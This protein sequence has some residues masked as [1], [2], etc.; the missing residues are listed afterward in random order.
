MDLSTFRLRRILWCLTC[1]CALIG[2]S[3]T[4]SAQG[5]DESLFPFYH[6]VA[7][8]DPL[9]DRVII[10]TRVSPDEE[11]MVEV[12]WRVATD[13]GLTDVV[14]SGLYVTDAFR[15]YTVKVDVDGLNPGTT[16]YY[17]FSALGKA[18]MVGKTKTAPAGMVDQLKF[19]VVSCSNYQH[20]YFNGFARIADR[21]DLDAVVHLG[22]YIY[23][24][25]AT[26]DDFYGAA[27]LRDNGERLHTPDKE[28][29][30][31][32]DY[33]TRYAQYRQDPD[34]MRVHQQHPFVLVWD[35]HESANDAYQ[36]GA[37]N[38]QPDEGEWTDRKAIAKQVYDEWMPVR[39]DLNQFPLYR[40]VRYGD[41]VDLI[42]LDTRLEGR[43]RQL[44]NVTD[45]ALYSADRTI[46]GPVQKD[47]FFNELTS[48]N[49]RWKVIGNQVIFS[50]FNVWWAANPADPV[51][52]SAIAL[53]SI[54]LDIWD[55]YPSER[56]QI[57][58]YIAGAETGNPIDNVV[59]LTGD[60]HS[61]FGY[62]VALR[63][64]P[65]SGS[66]PS[67]AQAQTAPVPVQPTY[68]PATG[69][70]SVAVE[71][72]TPSITSANF[73]EN[74]PP[75]VAFGFEAQI[76]NPLPADAGPVA[77]I[78]PNPHMKY[79]DLDRHGYFILDITPDRAQA[80]WFY[81]D[82]LFTRNDQE[83]FDEGWYTGNGDNFLQPADGPSAPKVTQD[84]AAPVAPRPAAPMLVV[85][86]S[87]QGGFLLSWTDGIAE[88][89]YVIERSI[90]GGAFEEIGRTE[91]DAES[92]VDESAN[93]DAVRY[94][95]K[96]VNEAFESDYSNVAAAGS[97]GAV[98]FVLVDADADADIQVIQPG[99]VVDL[100]TLSTDAL[101]VRAEFNDV[102]PASVQFLLDGA[103]TRTEGAAPY[104][105]GGDVLGDYQPVDGLAGPGA[106]YLEARALDEGGDLLE[107]G[108]VFFQVIDSDVYVA[109]FVLVDAAAD[110]DLE[111]LPRGDAAIDPAAYETA[112]LSLR[113]E[114]NGEEVEQVL[115][116]IDGETVRTE[117]VAPYALGGDVNGDYAAVE[118]L[119]QPGA[120]EVRATPYT[121]AG[122][123]AP[124]LARI[125]VSG[126]ASLRSGS[127]E[128]STV[129]SARLEVP[130]TVVLAGNYPNPFNPTTSIRFGLPSSMQTRIVLYDM[131]GRVIDVIVDD[132][133]AAGWHDA[134]F[135]GS[136]LASG[137]Y[138]YQLE[139]DDRVLIGRMILQK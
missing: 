87:A 88:D 119:V 96:A 116:E 117:S 15:D 92:F 23:E 47:W 111:V 17:G 43:E 21:T 52:N 127:F 110:T 57:I 85:E 19:A 124:L 12:S 121:S 11:G 103:V 7:S 64:A 46:L 135:D 95:I 128:R 18:S 71:F 122:P 6:G 51:L 63:P 108:R 97:A 9:T 22:D 20:G 29:L 75:P 61:A 13:P 83:A 37:E 5:I 82:D 41:L 39:S 49:A 94:R 93:S 1:T 14:R 131:L 59:I 76:N 100:R 24:I 101:S 138:I 106:F 77:G 67:I 10:W 73:D 139:T 115:F 55:G 90:D 45:P 66:D 118:E 62:D 70:G 44:A 65:L 25:S 2:F 99:A 33:R 35:D 120:F 133:L 126:G 3:S 74:L 134:Q 113:A 125:Q 84:A 56:D 69:E 42:M 91:E 36:D 28:I 129:E 107:A 8:G 109:G 86:Q 68:N 32:D 38:H 50:E 60:F 89:A 31:L 112:S 123:G 34:L 132:E 30:S 16:Y 80:D 102:A 27:S 137:M 105:L 54:F 72:A 79:T 26:G 58:N 78:N 98:T 130:E 40:T 4:A 114:V 48:S 104:A 53:E 81:T 136:S